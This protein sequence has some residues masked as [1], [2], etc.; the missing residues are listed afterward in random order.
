MSVLGVNTGGQEKSTNKKYRFDVLLH[1]HMFC[2]DTS[3]NCSKSKTA[4]VSFNMF[5]LFSS[6]F[7]LGVVLD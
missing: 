3:L 7:K 5:Y 6:S 2:N 1:I 4:T